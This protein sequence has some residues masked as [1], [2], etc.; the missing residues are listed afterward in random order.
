LGQFRYHLNFSF[1]FSSLNIRSRGIDK[2]L[3]TVK[4]SLD[5]RISRDPTFLTDF[6]GHSGIVEIEDKNTDGDRSLVG[7]FLDHHG[8]EKLIN[9]V[10]LLPRCEPPGLV[11]VPSIGHDHLG[12][13]GDHLRIVDNHSGVIQGGF[14]KNRGPKVADDTV[15]D[16]GFEDVPDDLPGMLDGVVLAKVV[17]TLVAGNFQ[18]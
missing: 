8:Q 13:D 1:E 18:L 5:H 2:N 7:D 9:F 16:P 14:M 10:V 4:G 12:S 3:G 11:V 17:E 15:G 6:I